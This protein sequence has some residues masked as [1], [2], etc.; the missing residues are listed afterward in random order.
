MEKDRDRDRN[1]DKDKDKD[2]GTDSGTERQEEGQRQGQT[3]TEGVPQAFNSQILV[4]ALWCQ[5]TPLSLKEIL[6]SASVIL[7]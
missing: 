1:R 7:G 4:P 2:S 5:G 3:E 6:S